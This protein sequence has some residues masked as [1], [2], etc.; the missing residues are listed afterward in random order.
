[1][2]YEDCV[3]GSSDEIGLRAMSEKKREKVGCSHQAVDVG[4]QAF[5]LVA[6]GV[7]LLLQRLQSPTGASVDVPRLGSAGAGGP[8]RN[9]LKVARAVTGRAG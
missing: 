6:D 9:C 5:A 7:G 2:R 4:R 8:G 1:V 3:D